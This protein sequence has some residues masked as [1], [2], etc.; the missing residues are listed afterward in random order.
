MGERAEEHGSKTDGNV[1][2]SEGQPDTLTTA[3]AWIRARNVRNE[4]FGHELFFD[5][6]WDMLLD[7]F[8]NRCRDRKV[9]ISDLCVGTPVPPTTALR[10]I[11]VL[12]NK[13]LILRNAD[14]K[15]RRRQFLSLTPVAVARMEVA[16]DRAIESDR[17]Y[18]LG[19][20]RLVDQ[21]NDLL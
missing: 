12:E 17:R 21:V 7:L 11:T 14:P 8:V 1:C 10:W 4:A 9:S 3:L 18:G 16:L 20:L 5:P 2:P 15:D 19:R 6:A 13:G